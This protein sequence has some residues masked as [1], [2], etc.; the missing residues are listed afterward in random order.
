MNKM[1]ETTCARCCSPTC[2]CAILDPIRKAKRFDSRIRK[3]A[4][5]GYM[6]QFARALGEVLVGPCTR[7][8]PTDADT[9]KDAEFMARTLANAVERMRIKRDNV[10]IY[11][12]SM[13]KLVGKNGE[14]DV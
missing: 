13:L 11:R 4:N 9:L 6:P 3:L 14:R 5:D 8:G 12:R 2:I 10:A 7:H 1:A